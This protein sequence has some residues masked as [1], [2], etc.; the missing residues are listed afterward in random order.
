MRDASESCHDEEPRYLIACHLPSSALLK[1]PSE[2]TVARFRC[3]EGFRLRDETGS[4]CVVFKTLQGRR[5]PRNGKRESRSAD[6]TVR[7]TGR[8]CSGQADRRVS[9][10]SPETGLNDSW[11]LAEGEAEPRVG[12]SRLPVVLSFSRLLPAH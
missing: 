2:V 6:A 11:W 3:P 10:V 12:R 4:R 9:L 8:R 7:S 5:C 1:Q